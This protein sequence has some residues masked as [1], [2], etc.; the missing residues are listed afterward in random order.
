MNFS[1]NQQQI[2][3]VVVILIFLGCLWYL[4]S[5]GQLDLGSIVAEPTEPPPTEEPSIAGKEGDFDFYVLALS[6]SPEYCSSNNDPQQCSVGRRLGFVLHGLWPQYNRGYPSDCSNAQLPT[7]V[8]EQYV[9]IYPSPSLISHE[10]SKH[11]TCSGLAPADYL[12]LSK[13]IKDSVIIPTAYRAP[14]QPIRTTS[15]KLVSDFVAANQGTQTDTFTT[16]CTGSGRYLQELRVC[17][18]KDG[19]PIACSTEIL[20]NSSRSCQAADFLIRNVR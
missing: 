20:R 13:R 11:G 16:F 19:K 17:F 3:R 14:E 7:A 10:W 12:G 18:S 2:L 1:L 4:A 6:W 8:R 5:N 9:S 15:S